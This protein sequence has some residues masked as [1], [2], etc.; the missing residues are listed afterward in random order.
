MS[1]LEMIE[2]IG[3]E[4]SSRDRAGRKKKRKAA[5]EGRI[6]GQFH[7][8]QKCEKLKITAKSTI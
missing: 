5:E 4:R 2:W 6:T 3:W 8:F 1:R 7:L